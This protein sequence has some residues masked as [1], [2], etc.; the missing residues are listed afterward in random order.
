MP[1]GGRGQFAFY[2]AAA[3]VIGFSERF[4]KQIVHTA[5]TG[6]GGAGSSAPKA[7]SRERLT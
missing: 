7:R 5:E 4:A 1:E 6:M 3:F 2:I